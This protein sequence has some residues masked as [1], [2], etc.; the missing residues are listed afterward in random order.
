MMM[1]Y[2]RESSFMDKAQDIIY[3]LRILFPQIDQILTKLHT[4]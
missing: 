1:I 3:G 4:W 2:Q